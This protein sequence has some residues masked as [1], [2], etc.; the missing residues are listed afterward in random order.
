M[1]PVPERLS[2][3]PKGTQPI[4][5]G[6][7]LHCSCLSPPGHTVPVMTSLEAESG[8]S[9]FRAAGSSETVQLCSW[10]QRWEAEA[11]RGHRAVRRVLA[12]GSGLS[13]C[14]LCARCSVFSPFVG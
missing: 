4:L 13:H 2:N 6:L 3:L 7:N 14:C 11:Q 8:L 1:V 9:F 10:L 5:R 12:A